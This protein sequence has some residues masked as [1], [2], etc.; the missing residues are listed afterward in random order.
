MAV[1]AFPRITGV[2]VDGG[3]LGSLWL[4]TVTVWEDV[5]SE[6]PSWSMYGGDPWR[7]N[8]L[9]AVK[10]QDLVFGDEPG[11][12]VK[13]SF[14]CYPSPLRTGPL[15]VRGQVSGRARAQA[16]I[17]NLEGE[18]IVSSPWREV[19]PQ[20]PFAIQIDMGSV[21]TGLYI[22]RLTIDAFSVGV[23]EYVTQFAV[24]H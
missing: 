12:L 19:S 6:M 20:S 4:S 8:W 5:V 24:V 16:N 3:E 13:D 7:S 2:A 9:D 23:K 11:G 21:V 18:L 1:G 10:L 14:S 17:Y 22:C 15:F